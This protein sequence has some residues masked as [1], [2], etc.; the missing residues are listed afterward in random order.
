[1]ASV[2]PVDEPTPTDATPDPEDRR[3]SPAPPTPTGSVATGRRLCVAVALVEAAVLV[4]AAA[5]TLLAGARGGSLP[6]AVGVAVVAAGVAY[7]LVEVARAFAVGRR[8]P[9]GIF[10]TVQL[11]VGLVALSVGSPAVLAIAAEPVV[12]GVTVA[13]V[14]LALT[15]LAGAVLLGRGP[16]P[17]EDL[18]VL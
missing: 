9:S 14:L 11:L 13:A 15:G 12:G 6:L 3:A 2:A 17:R 1:M 5:V 8:W 10:V 16:G 4:G 18:P 7:L